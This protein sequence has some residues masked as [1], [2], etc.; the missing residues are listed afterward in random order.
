MEA[1]QFSGSRLLLHDVVAVMHGRDKPL[2][3]KR[4]KT[5]TGSAQIADFTS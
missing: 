2:P 1:F 3:T 5:A 4:D